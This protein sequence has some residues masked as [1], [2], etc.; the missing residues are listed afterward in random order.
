MLITNHQVAWLP[1]VGLNT[2]Y[3]K[4]MC[5][6]VITALY[7]STTSLRYI[8]HISCSPSAT[9]CE[10]YDIIVLDLSVQHPIL[11]AESLT[12]QTITSSTSLKLFATEHGIW[13]PHTHRFCMCNCC[14]RLVHERAKPKRS[15]SDTWT[16]TPLV[17]SIA[18]GHKGHYMYSTLKAHHF[19]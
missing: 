6:D 4:V 7:S 11:C 9:V 12:E 5:R 19:K 15:V 8:L 16:I 2:C 17:S 10:D 13:V 18:F 1:A 14:I 3:E